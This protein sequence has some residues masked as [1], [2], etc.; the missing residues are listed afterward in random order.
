MMSNYVEPAG[1]TAKQRDLVSRVVHFCIEE[2]M[3]RMRTL[4]IEILLTK[5]EP[6]AKGFC[7][8][9]DN[10]RMFELEIEKRMTEQEIITTVCH[11]MVHVKQYA[12]NELT[13]TEGCWKGKILDADSY[14]NTSPW[15][16][17]AYE[18]EEILA[19]KF[20]T[21]EGETK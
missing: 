2:L 8:M 9:T 20:K 10:N 14:G 19:L 15:E 3:P 4:D 17:E 5:L 12:R 1:G 21:T 7:L 13:D 16:V 18:A 6:N 11:E